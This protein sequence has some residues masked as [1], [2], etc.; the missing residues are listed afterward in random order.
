MAHE[1]KELWAQTDYR[2]WYAAHIH[3][4]VALDDI[5]GTIEYMR[6]IAP[7]CSWS[8]RNGYVNIPAAEAFVHHKENGQ[9]ARLTEYV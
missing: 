2:Y 5:G 4:K 8:D 9:I 3:H 7:A 6:T 1:A